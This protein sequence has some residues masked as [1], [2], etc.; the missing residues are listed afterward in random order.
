M[1]DFDNTVFEANPNWELLAPRGFRFY[2][3]G[4]I[5]PGWLDASTIAQVET[6]SQILPADDSFLN[7]MTSTS[8][9]NAK[10]K[11]RKKNDQPILHFVTQQCPLLL[12]REISELFPGCPEVNSSQLTIITLSQKMC[13]KRARW[14]EEEETE[15]VAKYVSTLSCFQ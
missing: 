2:L 11:R 13:Q 9:K 5:G 10:T 15:K 8:K 7:E 1:S 14:S 6:H 12:R 3:P 4:S